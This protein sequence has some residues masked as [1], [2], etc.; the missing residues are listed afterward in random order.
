MT[1]IGLGANYKP[2]D[3]GLPVNMGAEE[4]ERL[5]HGPGFRKFPVQIVIRGF[6]QRICVFQRLGDK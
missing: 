5:S 3:L 4:N 2:Y 1:H 6:W